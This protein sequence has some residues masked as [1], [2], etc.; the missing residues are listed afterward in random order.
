MQIRYVVS[1]MVFW[2]R[3][4]PLSFEQEC[5]FLRSQGFGVELWPNLKGLSE[6]RYNKRNWPRLA[7]A[8][9]GMLVSMRSRSDEPT[10]EQWNE[11]IE[12][13]K[14][15][16][17]SIVTDLQNLGVPDSPELDGCGFAEEVVK[18]AETN[19]VKLSL[20]TGSL[21]ML[22]AIGEKFDSVWYCLDVG[23]IRASGDVLNGSVVDSHDK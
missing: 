4:H 6:C 8:T 9:D 23:Y 3:E 18:L 2:W 1:T 22:K 16:G 10:L 13:A 17:A 5:E 19:K 11:Q 12:C 7:T 20:E 14:L 21:H 15:L